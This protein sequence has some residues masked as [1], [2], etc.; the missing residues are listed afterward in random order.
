M[1]LEDLDANTM[2]DTAD[3]L[4]KWLPQIRYNLERKGMT[5]LTP[6]DLCAIV[7]GGVIDR[8]RSQAFDIELHQQGLAR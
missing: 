1:N 8:L 5:R 6:E 3:A 7:E 2:R 4:E